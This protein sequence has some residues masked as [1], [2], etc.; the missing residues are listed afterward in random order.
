[1]RVIQVIINHMDDTLE[2]AHE[3]YRDY[4][5]FKDS[6]PKMAQT[7]LEMASVHLNLYLK[8]HDVV[9]STINDYK[10]KSGELPATMK[11]LYDYEHQKLV[12]EYDEINYK[13]KNAKTY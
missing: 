13:V 9:V 10:A 12:E 3:Y 6:H 2:E 5:M 11:S 1:M 7:A 4:V 8:W